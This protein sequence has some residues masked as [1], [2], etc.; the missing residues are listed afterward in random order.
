MQNNETPDSIDNAIEEEWAHIMD[1]VPK[2][3]DEYD[4]GYKKPPKH[5]QYKKGHSGN[6]KGRPKRSLNTKTILGNELSERITITE[7]GQQKRMSKQEV[8]IKALA[9]N[10]LKGDTKSINIVLNLLAQTFG[11]NPETGEEEKLS[12]DDEAIL[13]AYVKASNGDHNG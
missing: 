1:G 6:S 10:A 8:M 2:R 4:V 11:L 13:A 3:R 12:Q 9:A 5:T 7:F